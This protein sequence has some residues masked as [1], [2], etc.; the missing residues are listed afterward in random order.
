MKKHSFT[1]ICLLMQL[2]MDHK[3]WIIY[4]EKSSEAMQMMGRSVHLCVYTC[5][6]FMLCIRPI[7]CPMNICCPSIFSAPYAKSK[8]LLAIYLQK[9]GLVSPFRLFFFFH[10]PQISHL[11]SPPRCPLCVC[12]RNTETTTGPETAE[13]REKNQE[14]NN[15]FSLL[16]FL[17]R[18]K[19]AHHT[20]I[21]KSVLSLW[22]PNAALATRGYTI[23]IR[24]KN[25][26]KFHHCVTAP[27]HQD[28]NPFTIKITKV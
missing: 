25:Q 23:H 19:A 4:C 5:L 27:I 18:F 10:L 12:S 6:H 24:A 20:G 2:H 14:K 3:Q 21:N 1:H 11:S 8:K 7:G 17:Q 16:M 13:A 9:W 22:P 15:G 28:T 26:R